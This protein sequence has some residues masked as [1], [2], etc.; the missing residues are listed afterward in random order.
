MSVANLERFN[1][2][3]AI[4]NDPDG[5]WCR[6]ASHLASVAHLEKALN[7]MIGL[8]QLLSR[9]EDIPAAIRARMT[10]NHRFKDAQRCFPN[11]KWDEYGLAAPGDAGEPK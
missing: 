9:N 4:D 7:G 10:E 5:L 1:V 6:H 2:G 3:V 8:V 11:T